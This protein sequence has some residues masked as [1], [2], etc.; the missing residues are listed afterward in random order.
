MMSHTVHSCITIKIIDGPLSFGWSCTES[1][2]LSMN[3]W[4]LCL[5][6]MYNALP[7]K[8]LSWPSYKSTW[9]FMGEEQQL[10]EKLDIDL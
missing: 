1:N 10:E 7:S 8:W 3:E 6:S 9:G 5:R 2:A 4:M